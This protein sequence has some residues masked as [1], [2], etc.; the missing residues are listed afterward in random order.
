MQ[1]MTF[2]KAAR[3]NTASWL[4]R[5][6]ARL[7]SRMEEG[8]LRLVLPGGGVMVARGSRQTVPEAHMQIHNWRAVW[9][10]L[11]D[12]DIG[13]ADGFIEGDWTS[14]DLP[15]LIEL[16]SRNRH[17]IGET[18]RPS[19]VGRAFYRLAHLLR[20]NTRS[21]SKRNIVAH[22]DLGNDFYSKWLDS[23][24][25]YSS[26]LYSS[27]D[28]TLEDAQTAKQDRVIELMA[29]PAAA[30]V[31]EIGC[32]WGGL[33]ERMVQAGLDVTGITLSPAQITYAQARLPQQADLRLQDY[34]DTEGRFDRIASVEMVEAVGEHFWPVYFARLKRLLAPG[35]RIVLQAITIDEHLFEGYRRDVDFIQRSIFPGGCLLTKALIERH[36]REAG[37][38]L[39]SVEQFGDSY[40]RTLAEWRRRFL[41]AWPAIEA[42][43]FPPKFRRLWEYYLA[44]CEGGFRASSIDVGLYCAEHAV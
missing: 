3:G 5:L 13:F 1:T 43:G 16:A 7:L 17:G 9:R 32:G 22:Y 44:Y 14:N 30:R 24:M 41:E 10:M 20:S 38:V 19:P 29:A 21:G 31:L 33:A 12:G 8:H 25:S 11:L 34:R 23:G 15:A 42:M 28:Q 27:A 6:P 39:R 36:M 26:A 37:L 35:G 40:A 2:D 4:A 18:I